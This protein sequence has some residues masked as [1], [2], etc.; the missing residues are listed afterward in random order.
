LNSDS[1]LGSAAVVVNPGGIFRM[2]GPLTNAITLNSDAGNLAVLGLN[3]SPG[4]SGSLPSVTFNAN[5]GPF[6][7]T[8]G[9]DV[10]GFS[11]PMDFSTFGVAGGKGAYLGT[12]VGG[13]YTAASLT[14]L[15][16]TYR[17]GTGGGSLQINS[18]V[19]TGSNSVQI[20]AI[21]N[22][23]A[24]QSVTLTNNGGTVLLN[25]ANSYTGGTTVNTSATL[26]LG[27]PGAIGNGV[28]TFNGGTVQPDGSLGLARGL[29]PVEVSNNIAFLGDAIF[30][31]STDLLLSGNMTLGQG[32]GA[33]VRTLTQNNTTGAVIV[34]GNIVDGAGSGAGTPAGRTD[35]GGSNAL[36][37]IPSGVAVGSTGVVFIA[38]AN[39]CNVR[40]FDPSTSITTT[41][42]GAGGCGRASVRRVCPGRILGTH[43]GHLGLHSVRRGRLHR[44]PGR[45][46]VHAV[47][48]GP[49]Q[50]A[51]VKRVV[52]R[53]RRGHV[54]QRC[55]R[56][57][58]GDVCRVRR[59][60]LR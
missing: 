60:H 24:A 59:G 36:F 34:S 52:H 53:V 1:P 29:K 35:G 8:V 13:N 30:A 47:Q 25:T 44:R 21:S 50:G 12:V 23:V 56:D 41:L 17:L 43:H 2:A 54:Q 55:G 31:G 46:G 4:P 14:P 38:D 28:L 57:V 22:V 51:R 32:T 10:V 19:L 48:P 11:M 42:T 33:S 20:G 40:A 5:G 6:T 27:A 39:S 16:S 49:L 3:Y 9:I 58:R 26:Q 37:N 45:V 7:G 15:G 18:A